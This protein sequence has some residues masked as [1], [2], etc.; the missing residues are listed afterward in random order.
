MCLY[1]YALTSRPIGLMK[2]QTLMRVIPY[3]GW[4]GEQSQNKILLAKWTYEVWVLERFIYE[5]FRTLYY[6]KNIVITL[7]II[8]SSIF[9]TSNMIAK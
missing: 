2:M 1:G 3:I 8:S 9:K 4:R 5:L 7:S 6:N